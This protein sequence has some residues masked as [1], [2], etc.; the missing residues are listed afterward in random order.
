MPKHTPHSCERA[1]EHACV[2][3]CGERGE[4]SSHQLAQLWHG[5]CSSVKSCDLFLNILFE[6]WERNLHFDVDVCCDWELTRDN[7][8]SQ[9]AP[10]LI[11]LTYIREIQHSLHVNSRLLLSFHPSLSPGASDVGQQNRILYSRIFLYTHTDGWYPL[12]AFCPD[13]LIKKKIK[14]SYK[15]ISY[16]EWPKYRHTSYDY[17]VFNF[18]II[19][20]YF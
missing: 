10:V 8:C 1:S 17:H 15:C 18:W 3:V 2:W 12:V 16:I 19:Y 9:Q 5:L 20:L 7:L 4:A 11:A 13:L 14:K 6:R